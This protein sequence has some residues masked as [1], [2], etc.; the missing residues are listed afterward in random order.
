MK[1]INSFSA[2]FISLLIIF[3]A[4]F[5]APVVSAEEQQEVITLRADAVTTMENAEFEEAY[6]RALTVR[7]LL[8]MT[9]V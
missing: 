5:T 7:L 4:I 1:R 6:V 2:I 9:K 3:T 8:R